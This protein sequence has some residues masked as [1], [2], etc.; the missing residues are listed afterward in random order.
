MRAPLSWIRDFTP[1]EAP[2]SEI[3]DALNQLGL[4]VDDVDAPG[5]EIHDV[6]AA[7]IVQVVPHPDADKIRLADI[8]F[9]GGRALRVVCGA[10]NI[11]A[12]MVVPF[13][14]VGAMLPGDFRITKRKIRGVVSEGMLC[15][16][17]ELGLGD[18]HDGILV[19]PD[20]TELGADVRDVLGLHDVVFELS[21]TP[22][23]PDAMGIVGVARDLAAHFGLPFALPTAPAIELVDRIGDVS[24]VVDAPERCPRLVARVATVVMGES[25]AWMQQRLRLAG[26]RPIS[27]VVDVTNYVMLERCRPLHAFDLDRLAG[28]GIV[29]RVATDGERMTTLD[30][31]ERTLD[32]GDLVICDGERSPQAIAGIMGGRDS[33]VDASTTKILLESAY[34]EPAGIS[35]SSKRLG[36][37]SEASARFERGV[38]PN[39]AAAGADRALELLAEVAGAVADPAT[40]DRYPRPVARERVTV[41]SAR[42]NAI[43][44]TD[45]TAEEV[46]G[47]VEPLGIETEGSDPFI[48]VCPTDRPDLAREIDVIEEIARRVGLQHIRRT[49]ASA[50]A[51][52]VGRLTEAQRERRLVADVLVGAGFCEAMSMPLI[53]PADLEHVGLTADATV[54]VANPL[55]AEE[56]I[57]RPSVRPG[58][59]R[60]VAGN[61]AR[62]EPDVALF[63]LGTVFGPPRSGDLLP[64][65]R[66]MLGAVIAGTVRRSPREPDRAVHVGDA[67]DVV[68]ALVAALRLAD[69]AIE[70][71][72]VPGLH[73]SR[74]ARILVDGM[75]IGAVGEVAPEVLARLDLV[76]PVATLEL[77]V[78]AL[79]AGRRRPNRF[80]P[81]SS[82]P[83][84]N[85]DLAFV[86]ADDVAAAEIA[87]TVRAAAGDLLE[88]VELF[89]EFRSDALGPG[90]RS[91]AF[92]LRCRAHDRTL[93]DT[94]IA[95]LRTAVIDA[96][97]AA[98][99]AILRG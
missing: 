84:V 21:I 82:F 24:V 11:A 76:G 79:C 71:V 50:P 27:N 16:S 53:S 23:R 77:D 32:G 44:G 30:G 88:R 5:A 86:V 80:V 13:A 92:A 63:E 93:T 99:D 43:L 62:G 74:S 26:M 67:V 12:G 31:V 47:L 69:L 90:R 73:A 97:V 57:L 75:V 29:V 3:A 2:P 65:E 17:R 70:A 7:R 38:D 54:E 55:R 64:D 95:P 58:L 48:A 18:D 51:G 39:G 59:L 10:P 42:V 49:V 34:F 33:E 9:G 66:T 15:S 87:A 60:A 83:P 96:V 6:V 20:D 40:I 19:L 35:R 1:I 52:S 25:P 36:L 8:E 37:R 56:S 28:R 94:E 14:Q 72:A 41:R 22:N 89:D 98:H 46:R 45:L 81:I 68:H 78:G 85:F 91:L 61:A 4:E